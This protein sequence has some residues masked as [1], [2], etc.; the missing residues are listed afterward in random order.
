MAYIVTAMI[1]NL[2]G[3]HSASRDAVEKALKEWD[4]L[5]SEEDEAPSLPEHMLKRTCAMLCRLN[6]LFCF[7]LMFIKAEMADWLEMQAH[8]DAMIRVVERLAVLYSDTE[9]LTFANCF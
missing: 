1:E 8:Y 4:T 9:G 6:V 5:A 3:F 2:A 7:F